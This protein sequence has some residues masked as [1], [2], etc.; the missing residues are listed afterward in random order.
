LAIKNQPLP[1]Y[2]DGKQSRTFCYIEDNLD[3]TAKSLYR[4]HF[5]N[6]VVNIGS[7]EEITVE[8]LANRIKKVV[9]STSELMWLPPLKEGDMTRRKPDISKMR[10]VLG[11][12]LTCLEDGVRKMMSE[13]NSKKHK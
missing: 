2:G 10:S 13:T 4:G 12:E 3:V 5:L 7:D 11:R 1:I 8:D 9:N 6:D